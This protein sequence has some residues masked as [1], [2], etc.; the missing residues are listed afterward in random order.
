VLTGSAAQIDESIEEIVDDAKSR[1]SA[2][3]GVEAHATYGHA[4]EE[5][6]LFSASLDLLIVGSRGYGPMGRLIHGST[7]Q[8]LTHTV[9]CALLVLLRAAHAPPSSEAAANDR[10]ET[11]PLTA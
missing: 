2:L 6:A 7:S 4:A 11:L 8:Q 10:E 9:R 1:I 3:G 5:L